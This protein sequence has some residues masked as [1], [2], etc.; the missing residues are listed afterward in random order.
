[1]ALVRVHFTHVGLSLRPGQLRHLP[2][3]S[4]SWV[5]YFA[6]SHVFLSSMCPRVSIA[7]RPFGLRE[8]GNKGSGE[9]R[10]RLPWALLSPLR[11]SVRLRPPPRR[12]RSLVAC[13]A[14][15][16][17]GGARPVLPPACF[18][19][20]GCPPL[21]RFA[22]SCPRGVRGGRSVVPSRRPSGP[23]G[24]APSRPAASPPGPPP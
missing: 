7:R 2:I 22:G 23:L 14:F 6:T 19:S 15:A 8:G 4:T 18:A 3:N 1:M 13:P 12:W 20:G 17:S 10:R 9:F 16:P 5:R 11:G 21:V 24:F